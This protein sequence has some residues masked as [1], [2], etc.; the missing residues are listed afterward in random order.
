MKL[1]KSNIIQK[2]GISILIISAQI[3]DIIG[4]LINEP[5]SDDSCS[6]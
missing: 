1:T 4:S 6:V 3:L 2:Y 5:I